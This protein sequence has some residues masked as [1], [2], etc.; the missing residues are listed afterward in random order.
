MRTPSAFLALALV[1]V[2]APR[3]ATAQNAVEDELFGAGPAT[4]SAEPPKVDL[5]KKPDSIAAFKDTLVLGGRLRWEFLFARIEET[6]VKKSPLTQNGLLD[7]YFDSRPNERLRAFA[8]GRILDQKPATTYRLDEL[9]IKWDV[10]R[11][12]FFTLGRQKVKWGSGTFWNPTDFLAREVKD[13]YANVDER[14]GVTLVKLHV[15]VE[16]QGF[17][18]YLIADLQDAVAADQIGFA[19]RAE[20][21]FG[22]A[23]LAFSGHFVDGGEERFGL[24]LSAG[25][26]PFDV[27]FENAFTHRSQRVFYEGELDAATARL[28]TPKS[29]K[30]DWIRQSVVGAEWE[31]KYSDDDTAVL[32]AEGFDN[33]MGY[34]DRKLTAYALLNGAAVPLYAGRRYGAAF[35][36]AAKPGSFNDTTVLLSGLKNVSDGSAQAR[37][38]FTWVVLNDALVEASFTQA[39]GKGELHLAMPD[40]LRA[41][42]QTPAASPELR[43][44]VGAVRRTDQIL[45]LG[46]S[47]KL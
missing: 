11:T 23:E 7:L 5:R 43:A 37:L 36:R 22:D 39:M 27:K 31:F 17:N 2:I 29:R 3:S 34:E 47:A 9:W 35:L 33:G 25:V 12:A 18:F 20:L 40:D 10:A 38:G 1:I 15:P 14:S 19:P 42:A 41:F 24:D 46:M 8:R 45:Q 4:G 26:G 44:A 32:G 30:E 6:K 13:P 21:V 16:K 28:P